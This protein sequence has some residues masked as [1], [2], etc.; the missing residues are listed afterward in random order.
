MKNK[1]QRVNLYTYIKE[2]KTAIIMI[3]LIIIGLILLLLPTSK[4]AN[5]S[6]VDEDLRLNEYSK[7][8]ESKIA[9]LCEGVKGVHNVHVTVYFDS[10]FETIYAYNE[11]NKSS[12]SGYNS[13]KKYVTIGSGN[14]ESMVCILEKMPNICGVAIVCSGGGNP[15][16]SKELISLISSAYGISKN[17]IYVAEG[18]KNWLIVLNVLFYEYIY[19]VLDIMYLNEI[20]GGKVMNLDENYELLEAGEEEVTLWDKVKCFF[21]KIGRRNLI[22]IGAVL[23]IGVAICLNWVLFAQPDDG[24]DYNNGAGQT[25]NEVENNNT[26]EVL[27]YFASTQVSRDRARDEALAVLQNIVDTADVDSAEK[28]Q[29]LEEIATIAANI[30]AEA[31]IEAMVMA[32]GFEQ[33]VAILND[34]MCTVV[35]MTT[36]LL[37]SQISQINEIVYEQTGIKPVNIKYI[38]KNWF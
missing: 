29:A 6:G 10:G 25:G 20:Y 33:C 18:K 30:E 15:Q 24:Y 11:E 26:S 1:S 5:K 38:V 19:S 13:E 27:A 12:S 23:L 4:S 22:I 35:V 7:S 3:A 34:G 9:D 17:K 2:Q 36:E 16:I 37:P 8:I 32:R 31:N 28:T 14:D 21:E